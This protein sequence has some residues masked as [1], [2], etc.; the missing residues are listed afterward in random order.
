[1]ISELNIYANTSSIILDDGSVPNSGTDATAI[2]DLTFN[3]SHSTRNIPDIDFP[4]WD[5]PTK[6]S[7]TTTGQTIDDTSDQTTDQISD[8]ATM[9]HAISTD[10]VPDAKVMRRASIDNEAPVMRE[11]V[12]TLDMINRLSTKD[13]E[14]QNL[15]LEVLRKQLRAKGELPLEFIPLDE[16]Q[17][18][19]AAIFEKVN[20]G[21][22]F[23]EDRLDYLLHCLELNPEH[24]AKLAEEK[25]QWEAEVFPYTTACFEEMRG[26]MPSHIFDASIISLV[27]DDGLSK[28]LAKR[29]F[30]KKC[31]MLIRLMKEDISKMH[32]AELSGRFNP[33]AQGLDIVELAA[34]F[35][36]LPDTFLN[37][38]DG[39]KEQWRTGIQDSFQK[40][41]KQKMSNSLPRNLTRFKGYVDE[42][43]FFQDD[44]KYHTFCKKS[45]AD[46]SANF[47]KLSKEKSEK[48]LVTASAE[49]GNINNTE[50]NISCA[51][52]ESELERDHRH[53]TGK[54]NLM[55]GDSIQNELKFALKKKKCVVSTTR[56]THTSCALPQH[57]LGNNSDG[58]GGGGEDKA[59]RDG[60]T[61][62]I[63]DELKTALKRRARRE[64]VRR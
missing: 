10:N 9:S 30:M 41:Y 60:I 62:S 28:A 2:T 16:L 40:L 11:R 34:V 50:K 6:A 42:T 31:L 45:V 48:L 8:D 29:F 61:S 38:H 44:D 58:G 37:D 18:E 53:S 59:A 47:L 13:Q 52:Q 12:L 46:D 19:V 49:K 43:P 39:K 27:D 35:H 51:D 22:V 21:E 5:G 1:M 55:A 26:Y 4:A 56:A 33:S 36:A 15:T 25:K 14:R 7:E 63:Q 20:K 24:K 17:A 23:D 54:I 64:E 32:I 3:N 57:K